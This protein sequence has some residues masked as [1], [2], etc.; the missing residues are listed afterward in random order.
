M[1]LR[2][3][4]KRIEVRVKGSMMMASFI[5]SPAA[6]MAVMLAASH[7]S[8][9]IRP[10]TATTLILVSTIKVEILNSRFSPREASATRPQISTRP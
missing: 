1:G 10:S 2:L 7:L 5:Q 4:I 3:W 6:G 9:I 8:T